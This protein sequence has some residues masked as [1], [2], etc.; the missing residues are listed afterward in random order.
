MWTTFGI[1]PEG[2]DYA[3]MK[4]V[5][6]GYPLRPEIIESAY[7]LYFYTQDPRYLE[8]GK[9]FFDSLVQHCRTEAGYAAL[10]NVITKEKADHM[11][12]FFLAET[13][14]DQERDR[15][16]IEEL[17]KVIAAPVDPQWEPEDREFKEQAQR[18][19]RAPVR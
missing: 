2:M 10:S 18:R 3:T 15:E 7:Y 4:V 6:P 19:L 12:S 14:F 13:L 9:V 1:E 16:A 17:N 8:M 5:Y 11:E